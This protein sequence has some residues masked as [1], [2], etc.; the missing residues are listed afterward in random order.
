MYVHVSVCTYVLACVHPHAGLCLCVRVPVQHPRESVQIHPSALKTTPG[1]QP[2]AA[3]QQGARTART[4]F[5]D[6][7]A[8]IHV[9]KK[10]GR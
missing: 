6:E 8:V 4:S 9:D 3:Q 1:C 7:N 2:T 5:A 10:G